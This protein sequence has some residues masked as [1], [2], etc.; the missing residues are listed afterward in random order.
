MQRRTELAPTEATERYEFLD[1]LRGFAL[2]GIISANMISYSLYLNLSDSAKAGMDTH[3][4][5]RVLDFL[6]LLLIEGKFYTIFSV[7]FGVGFSILLSRASAKGWCFI[8]S[9]CGMSSSCFVWRRARGPLWHNDIL[10][11]YALCGALLL[12]FATARNR[13]II[14][15]AALALLAPIPIKLAGGILVG[16]SQRTRRMRSTIGSD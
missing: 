14:A 15:F 12:P 8:G 4:T 2:F 1:V 16:A 6:E 11:A 10:E 13:T 3:A 5:D 9:F 7:L